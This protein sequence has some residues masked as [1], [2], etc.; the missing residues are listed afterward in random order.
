MLFRSFPHVHRLYQKK[1][2]KKDTITPICAHTHT[3]RTN[4]RKNNHTQTHTHTKKKKKRTSAAYYYCL[5]LLLV[6]VLVLSALPLRKLGHEDRHH[7]VLWRGGAE[8][9]EAPYFLS[10]SSFFSPFLRFRYSCECVFFFF[11][12]VLFHGGVDTFPAKQLAAYTKSINVGLSLHQS[13]RRRQY[14]R[15]RCQRGQQVKKKKKTVQET[16]ST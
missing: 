12:F 14:N 10:V 1:R 4:R 15:H 16:A 5:L 11:L 6:L 8:H 7:S 13:F 9:S 3:I 2:G